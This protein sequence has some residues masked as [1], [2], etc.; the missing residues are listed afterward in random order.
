[1]NLSL[2]VDYREDKLIDVLKKYT[3]L[4]F[5]T[6]NLDVADVIIYKFDKPIFLIER[7]TVNDLNSSIKDGR[8]RE[9]KIRMMK[10]QESN[11]SVVKIIYVI[12]GSRQ[13]YGHFVMKPELYYG[14]IL[15]SI[16]RDD[17][18][19]INTLNVDDTAFYLF[20]FVK[21]ITEH[22]HIIFDSS[23]SLSSKNDKTYLDTISIKKKEN[24]TSHLCF[25][26]QLSQIVGV[27]PTIAD[28]IVNEYGSMKNL[29]SAYEKCDDL[30][31][32]EKMLTHLP[33]IGNILSQRIYKMLNE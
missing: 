33:K 22:E 18:L 13:S 24:M 7:K 12:E 26:R 31:T 16:L 8:H 23:L 2:I 4:R 15:N 28:T 27:S 32:K 19:I 17:L 5:K 11:P 6:A 14:V 30:K 25:I 9:Q 20:Y 3:T 29:I 10:F 1:M 21:K